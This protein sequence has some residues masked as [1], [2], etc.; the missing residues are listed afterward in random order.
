MNQ[1]Q[2]Y[3]DIYADPARHKYGTGLWGKPVHRFLP[4]DPGSIA[5]IGCG[6]NLF[7]MPYKE[8]FPLREASFLG[9]DFAAPEADVTASA[10]DL[11]FQDKSFHWVTSFDALEHLEPDEVPRALAEMARI[12]TAY[13][14]SISFSDSSHRAH[15]GSTLHPTVRPPDWWQ[16]QITRAGGFGSRWG[17]FFIGVWGNP[18]HVVS[19]PD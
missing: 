1:V 11:P 14:F 6:R 4:N 10:V 13:A 12:A 5:D 7:L 18:P 19:P 15:D 2:K 9:V 3:R 16:D 17:K 8:R